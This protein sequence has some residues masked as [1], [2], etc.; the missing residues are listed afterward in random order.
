MVW[1][2]SSQPDFIDVDNAGISSSRAYLVHTS[3]INT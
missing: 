1:G 3:R 2:G